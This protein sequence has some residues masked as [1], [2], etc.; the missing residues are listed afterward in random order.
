LAPPLTSND[1]IDSSTSVIKGTECGC[2]SSIEEANSDQHYTS[3]HATEAISDGEGAG[4]SHSI[5]AEVEIENLEDGDLREGNA[6]QKAGA[7]F[8]DIVSDR[9]K[10]SVLTKA[11]KFWPRKLKLPPLKDSNSWILLVFAATLIIGNGGVLWKIIGAPSDEA[12]S[13]EDVKALLKQQNQIFREIVVIVNQNNTRNQNRNQS[14]QNETNFVE[15]EGQ[16]E[17]AKA[18][19]QR[20]EQLLAAREKRKPKS[21]EVA[22]VRPSAP[23]GLRIVTD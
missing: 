12:K 19:Y 14:N 10:T 13:A 18:E 23:T 2:V 15:L 22:L 16:L 8:V 17:N 5:S 3:K 20:I 1:R 9:R 11:G 6:P 7:D 4:L 21:I